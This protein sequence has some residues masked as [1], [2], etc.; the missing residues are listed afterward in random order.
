MIPEITELQ[1]KRAENIIW[2]CAGSYSFSPDFKA[3]DRNGMADLYWNCIIGAVR[4]HYDYPVLEEVL[5]SFQQ[6]E[7]SDIYEGLMWLGLEN[8]VFQKEAAERPVLC[9]L[10]QAYA[11]AYVE[12]NKGIV[13]EDLDFLSTLSLAHWKRVLGQE[14][15]L[16]RY[17][18][19][20]LDELE[21]SPDLDAAEIA[22]RAKELFLRWF[23]IAAEEKKQKNHPFL[24]P[25]FKLHGN[26]TAKRRYRKFGI[27]IADHPENLYGG[28]S[29][30]GREEK[31]ELRTTLSAAELRAF[32]EA[33]YG[34]S[35]FSPQRTAEIERMLCSDSHT[36]CH[37]L[38]TYG[39]I[40]TY[41]HVQNAFEALARQREA[42]QMENNRKY[43][44]DHLVRNRIAVSKL[45]GNIR[46]SV[47]MHLEPSPVKANTGSLNGRTVWRAE[48]FG[49][50]DVFRK[51][52][53]SDAGNLCVD[54]LLDASTSQ[55]NRQ[56]IISS[57][58]Y[59]I[60]ESLTQC[61]IPCRVMSFC[62]MTGYTILRTFREYDKPRDNRKIFEYVSNGCNRDGLAIRAAHFLIQH[63]PFENRLLIVLSD[64]KPNDVI[65]IHPAHSETPQPYET[66]AGLTDTALEVR[67]AR[68]DG[69][70]VIC[71]FTGNDEDVPSAKMVYGKD[72]V[73]IQS[74]DRL[75]DTVGALIQ[76]QI[77]DM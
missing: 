59:I 64:V 16:S 58:G 60:A 40:T 67:R 56:E 72:F 68:A 73:R 47:L 36:G 76:N 2:S 1:K 24:L 62:S 61:R 10:R 28:V 39:D 46:N 63:A 13:T 18:E 25:V 44:Q 8:C 32:I 35:V 43:Y 37:L 19:K 11:S 75:A 57:Q 29:A 26:H 38:F 34:S 14:S 71:I 70:S 49:D 48:K 7:E 30:D 52:E 21:F 5:R 3:Y 65:K 23:Q 9:Q 74:F 69:I 51:D 41:A 55:K 6:Y 66:L 45:S 33:K 22:A 15:T 77:K 12:Q 20:L 54:I 27:G 53:H 4:K 17:D 42:A 31:L 50:E